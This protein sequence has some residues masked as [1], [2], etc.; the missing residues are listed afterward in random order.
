MT[1]GLCLVAAVLAAAGPAPGAPPTAAVAS[2][3][4]PTLPQ[5]ETVGDA[6]LA[7]QRGG[8]RIG[9]LEIQ[10]GADIRSYAGGRLMMQ[11]S[12]SWTDTATSVQHAFPV[13]ASSDI[14][15]GLAAGLLAGSGVTFSLGAQKV[16]YA[17]GGQTA[18]VQRTDGTIQNIVVNTASNVDLRQQ[19]D[20]QLDIRG[21]TPF[22]NDV[23]A[24]RIGSAV[25]SMGR[26]A[27]M[28]RGPE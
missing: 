13:D 21:F 4:V 25:T 23:L 11:T 15:S 20:V 7:E 22:R 2:E 18:F 6:E 26:L 28:V 27:L 19:V 3:A 8:F 14:A 24:A 12:L 5:A 10:L 17:N 9:S 16:A 1:A